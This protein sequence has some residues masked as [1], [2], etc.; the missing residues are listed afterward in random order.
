MIP[1]LVAIGLSFSI[2]LPAMNSAVS[3]AVSEIEAQN[4]GVFGTIGAYAQ[5]YGLSHAGLGVGMVLGPVGAGLIK[6]YA[7]WMAMSFIMAG[8]SLFGMMLVLGRRADE[9]LTGQRRSVSNRN[10]PW[11]RRTRQP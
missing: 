9:V 8:F 1:I 3:H 7:G 11:E 4:P 2:V 6:E 10:R 5:A